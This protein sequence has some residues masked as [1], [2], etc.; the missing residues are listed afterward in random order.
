MILKTEQNFIDVQKDLVLVDGRPVARGAIHCFFTDQP[1]ESTETLV[2]A[3]DGPRPGQRLVVFCD[4]EEHP[5]YQSL[6]IVAIN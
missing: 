2:L 3:E 1:A 4:G 5:I 6:P